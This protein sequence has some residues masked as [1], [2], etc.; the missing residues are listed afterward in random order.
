VTQIAKKLSVNKSTISR[1]LARNSHAKKGYRADF[2]QESYVARRKG[3][4]VGRRKIKE[5]LRENV[6]EKLLE[7]WSPRQISGYFKKNNIAKISHETIY[8]YVWKDKKKGGMLYQSL[9]HGGKKYQK[10]G[11]KNAG[12]GCI[13][14]RVGIEERPKIADEKSRIGDFEMDLI[15]GTE[16]SGAIV[17]MV[18]RKSKFTR[19]ALVKSKHA[20]IVTKAIVE[21][22]LQYRG[23]LHTMTFDNGKEFSK[24]EKI[25]KKLGLNCYFANPYHSWERGLNEH[26]NGEIRQYYPKNYKF[27]TITQEELQAVED[28]L[29]DRPREVLDFDTPRNVFLS[30]LIA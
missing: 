3:S 29:N 28:A 16:H 12:R 9:R 10:R 14:N 5:L 27:D 13:P 18:D 25:S 23:N 8:K 2:A 15:I 24:H 21:T 4:Y 26:T 1:E 17:S 22:M 11:S 7:K 20:S 19:L 6:K 30:E